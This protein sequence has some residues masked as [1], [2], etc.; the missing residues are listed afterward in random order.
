M[1]MS[2][3]PQKNLIVQARVDLPA[4]GLETGSADYFRSLYA[5]SRDRHFSGEKQPTDIVDGNN[6]AFEL[7]R[8]QKMVL[9]SFPFTLEL[10]FTDPSNII[11][12]S[13]EFKDLVA[14]REKF[15]TLDM[16][17]SFMNMAEKMFGEYNESIERDWL[18]LGGESKLTIS[19]DAKKACTALRLA[20][21]AGEITQG[22]V[23]VKR[24]E[25]A[26]FFNVVL[27]GKCEVSEIAMMFG[28]ER[29]L[30]RARL[31]QP[32][33]PRSIN[34]TTLAHLIRHVYERIWDAEDAA[35]LIA[36][37]AATAV[38]QVSVLPEPNPRGDLEGGAEVKGGATSAKSTKSSKRRRGSGDHSVS[39]RSGA[40]S[41]PSGLFATVCSYVQT[42]LS[43]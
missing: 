15:V 2:H 37:E 14:N 19:Y 4:Y 17:A 18:N 25:D 33:V 43:R 40:V 26:D 32:K 16:A 7:Y 35:N 38:P 5:V 27:G 9:K 30:Y 6:K 20:R 21:M 31:A 1:N 42:R 39:C 11:K 36:E 23:I 10:L 22:K 28:K 8:F 41:L 13:D 29:A 3:T 34:K 12:S 24:V